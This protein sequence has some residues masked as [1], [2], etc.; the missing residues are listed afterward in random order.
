MD[1]QIQRISNMKTSPKEFK[2]DFHVVKM[3]LFI[4]MNIVLKIFDQVK[5]SDFIFGHNKDRN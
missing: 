4:I 5:V 3:E 2:E 1:C